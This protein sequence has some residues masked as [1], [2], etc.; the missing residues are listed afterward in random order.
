[1]LVAMLEQWVK[2][3]EATID[4]LASVAVIVT[5]VVL[6][7]QSRHSARL[8]EAGSLRNSMLHL[9]QVEGVFLDRPDLRAYFH[10]GKSL[11]AD[12][13]VRARVLTIAG[14]LADCLESAIFEA[15]TFAREDEQDW[16]ENARIYLANSPTLRSVVAEHE[17]WWPS[18]AEELWN[19]QH[20]VPESELRMSRHWWKPKSVTSR[21]R[22]V[23]GRIRARR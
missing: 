22:A 1:M 16:R 13:A 23:V 8:A 20:G 17:R 18:V 4:A 12:K 11:P 6:A 19:V 14:T 15:H 3:H 10:D 5:L 9:A 21:I 2:A 7:L